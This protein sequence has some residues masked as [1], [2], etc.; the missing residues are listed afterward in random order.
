MECNRIIARFII[1]HY[2]HGMEKQFFCCCCIWMHS[3][4]I[5]SRFLYIGINSVALDY[6]VYRVY[7]TDFDHGISN[8][9]FTIF[10]YF[11]EKELGHFR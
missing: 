3:F 11:V 7:D 1:T 10:Q 6:I 2:N 9:W 5:I 4:A 8:F